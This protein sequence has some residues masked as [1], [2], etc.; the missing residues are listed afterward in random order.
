MDFERRFRVPDHGFR[1]AE[2]QERL[3]AEGD[4][5]LLVVLQGSM[6]P[7]RTRRSSTS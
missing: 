1:L 3:Y 4:R 7:A 5:A 6:R 2:L